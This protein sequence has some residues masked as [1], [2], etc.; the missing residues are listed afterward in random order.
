M[1]GTPSLSRGRQDSGQVSHHPPMVFL[2]GAAL[3]TVIMQEELTL[4]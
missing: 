2:Q 3:T 1:S 4:H